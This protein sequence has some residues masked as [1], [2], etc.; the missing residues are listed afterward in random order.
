IFLRLIK[1][2]IAPLVFATLVSGLASMGN[3]SAVGRV[4]LKAMT[5]FVTASFLSL[6]IGMM[7][8]NFFQPGVGMNLVAP[9]NPITTGLN[10]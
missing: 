2:I 5:W 8:A 10:T 4:G 7:L 3:S 9:V 1:M 6:L